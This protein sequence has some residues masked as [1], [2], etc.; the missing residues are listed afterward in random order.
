MTTSKERATMKIELTADQIYLIQT[1]VTAK[2]DDLT[3][4]IEAERVA[5]EDPLMAEDHGFSRRTV[6][7]YERRIGDYNAILDALDP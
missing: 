7:R 4:H 2:I 1:I 5:L 6:E 3:S